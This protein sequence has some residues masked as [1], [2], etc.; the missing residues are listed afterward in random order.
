VF[1]ALMITSLQNFKPQRLMD[2]PDLDWLSG[3]RC[4]RPGSLDLGCPNPLERSPSCAANWGGNAPRWSWSRW[5]CDGAPCG[6]SGARH[7]GCSSPRS[8]WSRRAG[9]R[10]AHSR[11]GRLASTG[12]VSAADLC[13]GAGGDAPRPGQGGIRRPPGGPRSRGPRAFRAQSVEGGIVRGLADGNDVADLRDIFR[14]RLPPGSR[15]A[16]EGKVR[17]GRGALGQPGPQSRS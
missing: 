9:L 7:W 11:R 15:Q 14:G 13:S 10:S 17:G 5:V 8:S 2:L 4:E 6:S 1:L 16:R 3:E 12:A